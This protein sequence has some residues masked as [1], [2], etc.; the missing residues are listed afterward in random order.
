MLKRNPSERRQDKV[1]IRQIWSL[2]ES[3][4]TQTNKQCKNIPEVCTGLSH[5]AT[6]CVY[7]LGSSNYYMRT[8]TKSVSFSI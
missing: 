8:G 1:L 5:R 2:Q 3:A 6:V 7:Y 4:F